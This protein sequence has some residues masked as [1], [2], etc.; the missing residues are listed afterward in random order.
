MNDK[1]NNSI[2]C[3]VENC[4]YHAKDHSSKSCIFLALEH[5]QYAIFAHTFAEIIAYSLRS[6]R[7]R[8]TSRRE[9]VSGLPLR[10]YVK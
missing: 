5:S 9:N 3:T 1:K 6:D 4:K 7:S 8:I 2:G 10:P